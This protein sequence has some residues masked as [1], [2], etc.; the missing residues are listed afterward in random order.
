M[1]TMLMGD[2]LL[3]KE[4][5]SIVNDASGV[6]VPCADGSVFRAK[7]VV[8]PLPFSVV[9]RIKF[10]PGLP[11]LSGQQVRAVATLGVQPL[12]N[13]FLTV[14]SRYWDVDKLKPLMSTDGAARMVIAEHYGAALLGPAWQDGG[15]RS[16]RPH[17]KAAQPYHHTAGSNTLEAVSKW[18]RDEGGRLSS[19][20]IPEGSEA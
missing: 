20:L 16:D 2:S 4:A 19:G 6:T 5:V 15:T 8:C 10:L 18:P 1:A 9:R 17:R 7:C 14:K 13:A 12:T 3:N 11:G